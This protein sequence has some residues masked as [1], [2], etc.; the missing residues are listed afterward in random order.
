[1]SIRQSVRDTLNVTSVCSIC[2]YVCMYIMDNY[3]WNQC[4]DGPLARYV[5]VRIA[6]APGMPGTF[7]RHRQV[8][9]PACIPARA[10]RTCRDTCRDCYLVVSF[11]VGGEENVPGIPG[12]CATRNFTYLIGVPWV[13]ASHWN[14]CDVIT[15]I[16][17][18]VTWTVTKRRPTQSMSRRCILWYITNITLPSAYDTNPHPDEIK[19]NM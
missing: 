12:T 10:S 13:V 9:I 7:P 4:I 6:Y 8:A 3:Y 2:Y 14:R 11:E 5:K 16:Y 17:A 19:Q 1:M 18:N 15:Y